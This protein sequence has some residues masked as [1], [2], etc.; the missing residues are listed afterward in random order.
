M[1][2]SRQLF[3]PLSLHSEISLD[4]G[5]MDM[6]DKRDWSFQRQPEQKTT[7]GSQETVPLPRRDMLDTCQQCRCNSGAFYQATKTI[8]KNALLRKYEILIMLFLNDIMF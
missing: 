6:T 7:R 2:K 5:L 8:E 4:V 3:S 1:S